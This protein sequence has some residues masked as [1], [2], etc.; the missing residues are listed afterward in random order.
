[1]RLQDLSTRAL[2]AATVGGLLAGCS[3]TG[4]GFAPT[5]GGVSPSGLRS[6]SRTYSFTD[7]GRATSATT[8][9]L[10]VVLKYR[11]EDELDKLV[12]GQGDPGSG[13]YHHFLSQKQFVEKFGATPEQYQATIKELQDA[14]FTVTHTFTNR[15]IIDASAPAPTAEQYFSTEI[16]NVRLAD[17]AARYTNVKPET[18]PSQL[19]KTVYT[20]VGLDSA[21]TMHPDYQ[22]AL[23]PNYKNLP[24]SQ[25]ARQN[26]KQRSSPPLFGPDSGYGPLVYRTSYGFPKNMTGKGQATGVVGDADFLDTD[27]SGFLKYFDETQSVPTTRVKV[28]G[29]APPGLTGDSVETELDV[30]TVVGIDPDTAL[31]LYT[32]PSEPDLR[33]FTDMYNQAVQDNKVGSVNTSYSE[34]ETA[35]VPSFRKPPRRSSSKALPKASRSTHPRATMVCTPTVA[36]TK[37]RSERRPTLRITFRSVERPKM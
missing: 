19:A 7:V 31:Y 20:V 4:S 12:D 15:T 36:A 11:N 5:S 10:A 30:E 1:M 2:V 21:H 6:P 9:N 3:G 32:V 24:S 33:Y 8:V 14:G 18:I 27:L 13:H 17:G 22:L 23:H 29:G 34:C 28:D 37:S 25:P 35:L 16:H 26:S